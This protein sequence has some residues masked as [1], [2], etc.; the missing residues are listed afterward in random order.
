MSTQPNWTLIG[1]II[2]AVP[3][4]LLLAAPQLAFGPF[5]NFSDLLLVS[6]ALLL[7]G[8]VLRRMA[9][10]SLHAIGSFLVGVGVTW[11]AFVASVL[12]F[13]IIFARNWGP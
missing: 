5:R 1:G 8:F 7:A 11:L 4:L 13:V 2:G 10:P 6:G 3:V 12:G 9:K